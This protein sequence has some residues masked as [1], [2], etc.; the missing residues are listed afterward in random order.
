MKKITFLF[1]FLSSTLL[2]AQDAALLSGNWSY[3]NV[4]QPEKLDSTSVKM[5]DMLFGNM[6]FTFGD[7]GRY[8]ASIV[9]QN[10]TGSWEY[11]GENL[12]MSSDSG[13][14]HLFDVLELQKDK[15]VLQLSK[16]AF[17]FKKT[18][19]A[20]V[21]QEKSSMTKTVKASSEQLSKRW[22]LKKKLT[23]GKSEQQ[24]E[25]LSN[26]L[27]GSYFDFQDDGTFEV[28]IMG[29]TETGEWKL[30]KESRK[31][32]TLNE[33]VEKVWN[34]NALTED[35]LVLHPGNSEEKWIFS[36]TE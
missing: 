30:G 13:E 20:T 8:A 4:F 34:I 36:A 5:L 15:M 10:D 24:N 9:G 1:L 11:A 28:S 2:S 33:Q 27:A 12:K 14:S 7:N 17:V 18:G 35:E 19:E 3:Q 6:S 25:M 22:Y 21:I 31:V 23:P 26:M 32:I 16:G 29:M